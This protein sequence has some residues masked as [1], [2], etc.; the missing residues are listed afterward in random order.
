VEDDVAGRAR[1]PVVPREHEGGEV[2]LMR[3]L[4]KALERG[5]PRVEG[6]RP[7]LHPRDVLEPAGDG[8]QQLRLLS[9]KSRERCVACPRVWRW[10][11]VG[12]LI[13]GRQNHVDSVGRVDL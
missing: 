12:S 7:G 2:D 1:R 6:R 8:V 11:T 5:G 3:E 10:T 9:L 13:K 4:E